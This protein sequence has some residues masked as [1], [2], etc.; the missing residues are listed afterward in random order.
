ME[1]L[2]SALE[3]D[4]AARTPEPLTFD[5]FRQAAV[6]VPILLAPDGLRLL[7]TVRSSQL[8]NHAGQIAFPGG[9]LD[10]GETVLEAALRE[11]VEETGIDVS[12]VRFLGELN[13]VPSPARYV[14]T[15][16]VGVLPWPQP[17]RL[18]PAEVAEVFTVPLTELLTLE[19]RR[20]AR[21]INGQRR[22][23]YYYTHRSAERERLIW[24]LTG[25]I[26]ADLLGVVRPL[27]GRGW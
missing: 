2:F 20:E 10:P 4:L 24:G 6:L 26:V 25:N 19:P 5:G 9:R 7:L 12:G 17:V 11:T 14:V 21:A 1:V 27:W 18:N 16:V 15:P 8:S 23:I 22:T 13:A 3:A